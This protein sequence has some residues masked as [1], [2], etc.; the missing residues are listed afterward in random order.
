MKTLID[1]GC[2]GKLRRTQVYS[3]N[4]IETRRQKREGEGE[5]RINR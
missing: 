2:A 3:K 5:V 1:S 4:R